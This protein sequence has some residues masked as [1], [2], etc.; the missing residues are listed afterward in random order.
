[1]SIDRD[2]LPKKCCICNGDIEVKRTETGEIY[3]TEGN[4]PWPV[5]NKLDARCCD[6]CNDHVVIPA[7]LESTLIFRDNP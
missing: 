2:D 7:R 4:D 6:V 3:W 1:M 5:N